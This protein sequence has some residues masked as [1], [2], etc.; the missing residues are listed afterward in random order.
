MLAQTVHGYREGHRLLA[1][2]GALAPEERAVVDEL[3]DL[4]GYLPDGVAFDVYHTGYPC[5]RYHAFAATWLDRDAPRGGAV[6]TH[7]LLVPEAVVADAADPWAVAALHRRPSLADLESFRAPLDL[8]DGLTAEGKAPLKAPSTACL[9][10]FF[11]QPDRPVLR[12]GDPP[13]AEEVRRLWALLWP[14]AR[15]TFA[16][17]TLALRPLTLDRRPFDFLGVPSAARSAFHGLARSGGWWSDDEPPRVGDAAWVERLSEGGRA[18]LTA[19]VADW[20]TAD[21]AVSPVQIPS[22][23]RL[24]ELEEPAAV[25]LTAARSRADLLARLDP[26]GTHTD[27]PAAIR[28]LVTQQDQAALNHRPLWELDDLLRR[29]Q[30]ATVLEADEALAARLREV[31]DTEV[32]RR[33]ITMPTDAAEALPGLADAAEAHLAP[34][35]LLGSVEQAVS[36]AAEPAVVADAI[37]RSAAAADST[38][39]AVA[40]LRPL[41]RQ[42]RRTL[43]ASLDAASDWLAVVSEQAGDLQSLVSTFADPPSDAELMRLARA[44]AALSTSD[45]S[46]SRGAVQSVDLSALVRWAVSAGGPGPAFD[47]AAAAVR[48]KRVA[49]DAI[50]PLCE[51]APHGP[52][53]IERLAPDVWRGELDRALRAAPGLVIPC[54]DA[55]DAG[56]RD[57]AIQQ[58]P[59]A[60]LGRVEL[61]ERVGA[62]G[63]RTVRERLVTA[64]IAAAVRGE[65]PHPAAAACLGRPFTLDLIA[66]MRRRALLRE[67]DDVEHRRGFIVFAACAGLTFIHE[68]R[69]QGP[70]TRAVVHMLRAGFDETSPDRV[71]AATDDLLKLLA[72]DWGPSDQGELASVV[73]HGVRQWPGERAQALLRQTF[74]HVYRSI[75][76]KSS[77]TLLHMWPFNQPKDETEWVRWLVGLARRRQWSRREVLDCAQGDR[78]LEGALARAW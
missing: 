30:L 42:E 57:A 26:S 78:R 18:A 49:L 65:L 29:P 3:S 50:A 51:G 33:V 69:A 9:K 48:S 74:V 63:S 38:A 43:L 8:P 17:C 47:V 27:W 10:A 19:L 22:L 2:G 52:A 13:P 58:A 24:S 4:S 76:R 71:D 31:V 40:A 59:A 46:S 20:Q 75:R 53:L 11:G 68:F 66:Q 21:F 15:R 67:L 44:W 73:A 77:W 62:R 34:G 36:Q 70:V 6:L 54:L 56:L 35:A 5:G 37:L 1:S 25:R 12:V 32:V 41:A 39:L 60:A 28:A 7:T 72:A 16:F 45:R 14:A 23:A 55:R 61:F 64:A